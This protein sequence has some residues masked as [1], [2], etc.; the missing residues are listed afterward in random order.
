MQRYRVTREAGKYVCSL[1]QRY[2]HQSVLPSN[3]E[4]GKHAT[5]HMQHACAVAIHDTLSQDI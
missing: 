2:T 3:L 5:T 1:S 4:Q